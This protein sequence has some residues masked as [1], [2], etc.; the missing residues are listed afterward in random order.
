MTIVTFPPD[1]VESNCTTRLRRITFSFVCLHLT[2]VM[3]G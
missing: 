3:N 1:V 2:A